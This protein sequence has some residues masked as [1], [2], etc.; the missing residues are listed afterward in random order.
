MNKH[1]TR[2]SF[3]QSALAA[4]CGVLLALPAAAQQVT[5]KVGA[6]TVNDAQ[7]EWMKQFKARVEK[8]SAGRI[9]V[10]I[11]PASQLGPI[12]R[13][14]EGLQLGTV[15]VFLGPT[16][17]FVGVDPRFMIYGVP[18][19][20]RDR[21]HAASTLH[22][23]AVREPLMSLADARGI[24]GLGAFVLG[25]P[26]YL[27]R[28]PIR[29]LDDFKGRKLRINASEVERESVQRLGASATPM[30]L[31]EVIP[32][33]QTGVIDGTRS[34]PAVYV[35]FKYG[36]LAKAMTVT[37]DSYLVTYVGISKLWLSRLP[38][39]LQK[40]IT[41]E[42]RTMEPGIQ[43]WAN[44]YEDKML[45][46]WKTD[47]GEIVRLP[48]GDQAELMKRM[49]GVGGKVVQDRSNLKPIYESVLA[50]SKTK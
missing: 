22:D 32:A 41:D 3:L 44:A 37:G 19:M 40:I 31:S 48:A 43:D 33:M 30:P 8:S 38:A 34:V 29:G 47:G 2:K 20:F 27:A 36:D 10:D 28:K 4:A 50:T 25:T 35:N 9:K 11:Y 21:A 1:I 45:E 18:G 6:A 17:F 5:M 46:Q 13:M 24:K 14:I 26:A 15:E 39:D 42:A 16:D 49:Q 12:P 7:H 23:A